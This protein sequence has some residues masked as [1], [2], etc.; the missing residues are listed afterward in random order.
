MVHKNV[1]D[2]YFSDLNLRSNGL[3]YQKRKKKAFTGKAKE[4]YKNKL[5]REY[6][7][8][9]GKLI[10]EISHTFDKDAVFPENTK[11]GWFNYNPPNEHELNWI[12]NFGKYPDFDPDDG[13][14]SKRV[15]L[16]I[17]EL[18]EAT[19][20]LVVYHY[21]HRGRTMAQLHYW[22]L[23]DGIRVGVI[24]FAY[25]R[26]S[27]KIFGESSM[28]FLE[29]ARLWITPDVQDKTFMKSS[30]NSHHAVSIASCSI[31]KALKNIRVDW[32]KK[33]MLPKIVKSNDT[34]E[35]INV[36]VYGII[37]WAD[38]VHH[39]GTVYKASN[40]IEKKKDSGGAYHGKRKKKNGSYDLTNHSDYMN[41]KT[42]YLYQYPISGKSQ[43]GL[44]LNRK[45]QARKEFEKKKVVSKNIELFDAI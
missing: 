8:N 31:G 7:I 25:P 24:S 17:A 36:D 40:F 14:L 3:Y 2:I 41:L 4:I 10:R 32:Y 15:S 43:K 9:E 20:I 26:L 1:E 30:D 21:L 39:E 22:I 37:S 11:K 16:E 28:N 6:E 12:K 35:N 44:S 5:K 18:K 33:Y 23:I 42:M 19:R 27:A 45:K 29:L 13:K 38:N 34:E